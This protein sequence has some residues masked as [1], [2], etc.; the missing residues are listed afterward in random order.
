VLARA[1]RVGSGT[2]NLFRFGLAAIALVM[3]VLA[4]HSILVSF[5][6]YGI[7]LE[8]PL[9]ATARWSSGGQP[10]LASSFSAPPGP[11][12]PF[13][14]P[15]VVLPF[16][17]PLLDLPRTPVLLAWCGVC[18]VGAVYACRR[19]GVSWLLVP[20]VVIWPPF[21][22]G[23]VGGNVQ[24]LLFACY[25]ALFFRPA[26][27]A[28]LL[29]PRPL[30]RDATD[31]ENPAVRDGVLATLIAALKV[32]QLHPWAWLVLHRWPAATLGAALAV[33]MCVALLPITGTGVWFD[34]FGQVRRAADPNWTL[35]GIALGRYV[36]APIALAI[37]AASIVA[38]RWV[39]AARA[40]WWV[41]LL[42][43]LGAPS[44]HTYGLLFML[45]ATLMIRRELALAAAFFISTFTEAG[46][47]I[48]IAIAGT[49]FTLGELR[50]HWLLEPGQ[51][52]HGAPAASQRRLG[53]LVS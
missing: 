16:L 49:T 13:L 52:T 36:G 44:L 28:A 50:W 5:A 20:A 43:V 27:P 37:T 3:T 2:N 12:L 48:G 17:R 6:P 46:F 38:L 22:E 9:R 53:A 14:Y 25:V 18:L 10:Y 24:V 41:G 40:G 26:R 21:S 8:I 31:P 4:F 42:S 51:E 30:A 1:M 19:L 34:W 29:D 35:A 33:G 15:P 32:A 23:I 45:P 11:D 7:D 47:W 39:P